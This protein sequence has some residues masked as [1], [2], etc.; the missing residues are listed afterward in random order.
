MTGNGTG[1]GFVM[2]MMMNWDGR[3]LKMALVSDFLFYF[4][5]LIFRVLIVGRRIMFNVM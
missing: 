2:M 1:N 4:F 3:I 5:V